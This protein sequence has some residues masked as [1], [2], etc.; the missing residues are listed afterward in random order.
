MKIVFY[1]TD[2]AK[3]NVVKNLEYIAERDIRF[4]STSNVVNPI[5]SLSDIPAG[6]NYCFINVL[7][8]YYFIDEKRIVNNG[9]VQASLSCDVLYTYFKEISESVAEVVESDEVLSGTKTDYEGEN[10]D[11]VSEIDFE[12]PFVGKSDILVT[13]QGENNV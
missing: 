3:I 1:K 2:T 4:L 12:N 7:K 8:R 6:A 13:V 11:T 10:V 9:I 5:L